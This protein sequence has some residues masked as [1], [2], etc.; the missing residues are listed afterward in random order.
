[1]KKDVV[2][3]PIPYG[4]FLLFSNII[5]HRRY[6]CNSNVFNQGPVV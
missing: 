1:M 2:T 5:P 3:V 6:A 4:S